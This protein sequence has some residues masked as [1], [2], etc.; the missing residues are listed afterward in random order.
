MSVELKQERL[1]LE[2]TREG[3]IRF[4]GHRVTLDTVLH[5]YLDGQTP[6]AICESF[7]TVPLAHL[8]A[9]IAFYLANREA[10]DRYLQEGAARGEEIRLEVESRPEAKHFRALLLARRQ[11]MKS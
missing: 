4:R 1:P 11:A 3:V 2:R 10:V 9:A 6:E 8:Y 7:P 5:A